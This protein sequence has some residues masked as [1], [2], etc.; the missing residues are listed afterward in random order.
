MLASHASPLLCVRATEV[1][2]KRVARGAAPPP[3]CATVTV[4]PKKP[5]HLARCLGEDERMFIPAGT[6]SGTTPERRASQMLSAM[7]TYVSA[8]IVIA[9][10]ENVAPR[11]S[12]AGTDA[13]VSSD[14]TAEAAR[15]VDQHAF[16]LDHLEA[17]PVRDGDAWLTELSR[18]SPTLASRIGEVRLAYA[19][20]DFE[21]H[22][23]HKLVID[24]FTSGNEAVMREW[25]KGAYAHEAA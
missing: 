4:T 3:R 24:G 22:N 19:K 12:L 14:E 21:W 1:A 15:V 9:Q 6:F 8:W 20:S 18:E 2:H 7:L 13:N 25:L 11:A 23:V 5:R 17:H 16:L 10:L